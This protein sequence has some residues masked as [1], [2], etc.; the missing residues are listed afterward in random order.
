[1]GD[2]FEFDIELPDVA[3][4][5][6]AP[7][8]GYIQIYG[9]GARPKSRNSAG[10]VMDLVGAPVHLQSATPSL[11][12]Q[13]VTMAVQTA[14][15][16]TL[17]VTFSKTFKSGTVPFVSLTPMASLSDQPTI[18]ELSATP[19]ATGCAIKTYRTKT[20]GVLLGG[21]INPTQ[22]QQAWVH[23]IAVGEAA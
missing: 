4:D 16:G 7:S 2:R 1:M 12:P 5:P 17:A 9:K 23:L 13:V 22:V 6:A 21:T 11:T 20:Q 15:D 8:S 19:T 3:A 18:A 10:V 14:A